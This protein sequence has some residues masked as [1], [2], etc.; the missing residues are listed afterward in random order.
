MLHF[1]GRKNIPGSWVLAKIEGVLAKPDR[2]LALL[3]RASFR[4]SRQMDCLQLKVDRF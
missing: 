4:V 2:Y 1:N 3:Q